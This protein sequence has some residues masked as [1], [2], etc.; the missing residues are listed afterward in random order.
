MLKGRQDADA[1][2]YVGPRP[3]LLKRQAAAGDIRPL[4]GDG[5]EAST[6]PYLSSIGDDSARLGSSLSVE[7]SDG[8]VDGGV[9]GVGIAEGAVGQVVALQVAPGALDVA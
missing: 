6:H 3:K 1:V 9:E 2:D 8:V 5:S 7:G 4:F